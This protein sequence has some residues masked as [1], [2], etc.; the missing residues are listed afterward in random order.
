M[1]FHSH[2]CRRVLNTIAISAQS[3]ESSLAV[4]AVGDSSICLGS[5]IESIPSSFSSRSFSFLAVTSILVGCGAFRGGL[6]CTDRRDCMGSRQWLVPS[7]GKTMAISAFISL[8]GGLIISA[9]LF[10]Y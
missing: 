7:L 8:F 4:I 9:G 2:L 10:A 5:V 3:S 6:S 1:K